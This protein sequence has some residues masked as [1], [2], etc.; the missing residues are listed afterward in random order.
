[1]S[2][3]EAGE[4]PQRK[5]RSRWKLFGGVYLPERVEEA[6]FGRNKNGQVVLRRELQ[7]LELS[8]NESAEPSQ[9]SYAGLGMKDGDLVMDDINKACYILRGGKPEKLADY[10][11]KY[12]APLPAVPPRFRLALSAGAFALLMI[13]VAALWLRRA[14]R[15]DSR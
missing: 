4:Q 5:M 15:A 9:F 7:L 3:D 10:G 11:S 14:S 13:V 2:T 1:M 8:V 6:V 12:I